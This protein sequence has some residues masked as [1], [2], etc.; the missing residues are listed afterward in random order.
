MKNEL[1]GMTLPTCEILVNS[2]KRKLYGKKKNKVYLQNGDNFQ[3]KLFNPLQERIGVQLKMNGNDTDNDLLILNPGIEVLI[4]R[5]IGTNRK[6]TFSSY[7]I[8]TTNMSE[9]KIKDVQ[10]AIEK[11]GILEIIFWNEQKSTI[12]FDYLCYKDTTFDI[13]TN[14]ASTKNY[15]GSSLTTPNSCNYCVTSYDSVNGIKDTV[16]MTNNSFSNNQ[17]KIETGRIE[18]G[19]ISNQYF[20]PVFFETG[21]KFY[22]IKFKLLP[23]SLKPLK[24]KIYDSSLIKKAVDNNVAYI[25][26]ESTI[27]EYCKCG[28]RISRGK[29]QWKFCP[30]C[31]RKVK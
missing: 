17:K 15:V 24:K 18:K 16:A 8:D 29:G 14:P 9:D 30:L 6:L 3:L 19:N 28:F 25:K 20:N 31:G 21:E 13:N 23:F 12:T 10:K 26:N 11:N 27:R 2:Q 7:N 4:E 22:Q 1:Q 5:F